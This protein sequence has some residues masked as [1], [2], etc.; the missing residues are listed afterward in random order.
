MIQQILSLTF[1]DT[2]QIK[3]AEQPSTGKMWM[4]EDE[5]PGIESISKTKESTG[6]MGG[7]ETFS[8]FKFLPQEEGVFNIVLIY[9]RP[10]GNQTSKIQKHQVLVI[11]NSERD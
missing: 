6:F 9:K 8:I 4:L 5:V 7:G 2:F 11:V 1:T 10:F 3:V